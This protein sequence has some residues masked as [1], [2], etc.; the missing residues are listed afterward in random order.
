MRFVHLVKLPPCEV[1]K[2]NEPDATAAFA[3]ALGQVLIPIVG[4]KKDVLI[5][6]VILILVCQA[7]YV[8]L[9]GDIS[10]SFYTKL[11]NKF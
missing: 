3:Y 10:D 9:L 6:S 7:C 4:S 8:L 2:R 1:R 5:R 11:E